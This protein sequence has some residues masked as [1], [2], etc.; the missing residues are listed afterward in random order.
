LGENEMNRISNDVEFKQALEGLSAVKQRTMAATFVAHVLPLSND[1]RLNRVISIAG[2]E[3]VMEDE[4]LNALR[5]AKA[6]TFD[7]HTR[8]GSEGDWTEQ[9]GYFVARAAVAAVTPPAQ[10]RIGGTAW[11][12]AMSSRMARTSMLIDDEEGEASTQAESEWQYQTLS[13][14]LK[15]KV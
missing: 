8:C 7:S 3:H 14:Y 13:D 12:A 6:A 9:A 10:S 5:S 15:A 2:V 1:E 4:L 11:R